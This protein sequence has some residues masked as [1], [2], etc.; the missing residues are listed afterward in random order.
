[1]TS[2]ANKPKDPLVYDAFL[3]FDKSI[4]DKIVKLTS[5]LMIGFDLNV[6]TD[7][8]EVDLTMKRKYN[9]LMQKMLRSKVVICCVNRDFIN[10]KKC[11]DVLILAYT[12]SKPILVILSE[13]LRLSELKL[14]DFLTNGGDRISA[15]DY[16]WKNSANDCQFVNEIAI[17]IEHVLGCKLRVSVS[18]DISHRRGAIVP[19]MNEDDMVDSNNNTA[20]NNK[21][22]NK[23]QIHNF[24]INENFIGEETTSSVLE[25]ALA[26]RHED[27]S[28]YEKIF[29][30]PSIFNLELFYNNSMVQFAYGFNRIVYLEPLERF[31]ITSS[32]FKSIISIDKTGK[33]IDKRNPS[34]LM[35]LPFAICLD[36]FNNIYIGDNKLKCI[37]VFNMRLKHLRTF[38]ENLLNGYFDMVIDDGNNLL[39]AI[40]LFDSILVSIDIKKNEIVHKVYVSSPQVS[41]KFF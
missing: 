22:N 40:N 7:L 31:L 5:L 1:M 33:Y 32:Y 39:Y 30:N 21:A 8:P 4:G 12:S 13:E 9:K 3:S 26:R 29:L 41:F 23:Y 36:K 34:G 10:S 38:G 19:V 15:I 28:K 18:S 14:V 37:F 16:L 20:N 11:K 2:Q 27:D 17:A 25:C 24:D 6:I 35:V